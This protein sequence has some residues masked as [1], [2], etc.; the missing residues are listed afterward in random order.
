VEGGGAT[1]ADD[2]CLVV[3]QA[4]ADNLV[5]DHHGIGAREKGRVSELNLQ[6]GG[7]GTRFGGPVEGP[8][9]EPLSI[10]GGSD[11][12]LGGGGM[13]MLGRGTE[14]NLVLDENEIMARADGQPAA[15]MLQWD[16]GETRLGGPLRGPADGPL[17]IIGGRDLSLGGEGV[18][19]I[20]PR[21]AHHLTLDENEILARDGEKPA[22]LYLQWHGGGTSFGGPLRGPDNRPLTIV[23]EREASLV[24]G[25]FL[26]VGTET[27]SNLTFD[28]SRI[29]AR[30]GRQ[31]ALLDVQPEGGSTRFG[32]P[33]EL[34]PHRPDDRRPSWTLG[35]GS[36]AADDALEL[37]AD[38]ELVGWIEGDGTGRTFTPSHR[39]PDRDGDR[40]DHALDIVAGLRPITRR[41]DGRDRVTV[42]LLAEEVAEVAPELV[43]ERD[44]TVGLCYADFSVIA[45]AA[46]QEQQQRIE[47]LEQAVAALIEARPI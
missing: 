16:G 39:G 1:V 38:G 31:S 26:T 24:D 4:T 3:G 44:G 42:G 29:L 37:R 7:G 2:G 14:A 10:V 35:I 27:G 15:L 12:S 25:G 21:T 11:L 6:G 46:I 5:I 20:G 22:T 30:R 32:G 19:L 45:I 17:N 47:T 13:L 28:D 23:G 41:L 40:L 43:S 33:I 8:V 9:N 18:V 34:A 36:A